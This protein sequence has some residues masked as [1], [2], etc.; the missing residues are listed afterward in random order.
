MVYI[1]V[2][3]PEGNAFVLLGYAKRFGKELN[4]DA[5]EIRHIQNKMQESDYNHHLDVFEE[6]FGEFVTL[7]NRP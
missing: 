1:D 4:Y 2:T 3:G 7:L 5:D 6:Y